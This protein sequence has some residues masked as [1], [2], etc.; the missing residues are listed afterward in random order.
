MAYEQII[1]D[2]S[3][4]VVTI[5]FN[6]PGKLNWFT[7]KMLGSRVTYVVSYYYST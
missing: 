4:S 1:L 3:A 2:K 7:F 6:R 5:T